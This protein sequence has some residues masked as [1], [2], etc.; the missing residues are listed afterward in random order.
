MI[1]ILLLAVGLVLLFSACGRSGRGARGKQIVVLGI[2]GM[3]PKFLEAH[4]SALP[5]LRKLSEEGEFKRLGTTVPPQSPVAWSTFITGLDPGGHGVYG[6]LHRDPATALPFS[7]LAEVSAPSR[8]IGIG[9]YELPIVAG[10]I[11]NIRKGKP[12]WQTLAEH[13]VPV[14]I[15]RMPTNF[16]PHECE[17]DAL[18]GMG[19]PDIRGTFGTFTFFTNSASEK[20]R[21][22]PGGDIVSIRLQEGHARLRIEGPSNSLRKDHARTFA[23]IEFNVTGDAAL[24]RGAGKDFILKQGEWSDW[25]PVEFGLVPGAISAHGMIRVYAKQLSPRVEIYVSPVNIDPARPELPISYPAQFSAD[26]VKRIGPFYTAGMPED[27]AAYRQGI[28]TKEEYI[29]QSRIVSREHWRLFDVTLDEFREGLLF[30]HFFGVDQDSHMLWGKDDSALLETYRSVDEAVGRVRARHANAHLIVMSD[31]G[32]NRFDR[33]VHLNSWLR[34]EGYLTLNEG[35]Q[36]GDTELFANVDWSRTRAYA[37]DLN[38][39]Y[40]NLE[41]REEKGTVAPIE[42]ASL[43]AE[44]TT[45]LLALRDHDT[46][47]QVVET[48]YDARKTYHGAEAGGGPD[49]LI[50]YSLG[51]R[52]SWQTVLG[53]VPEKLV[54]PNRD[55][56]A[57]D[58][59][60]AAHLVPGV[61][62]STKKSKRADPQLADLTVTLL[63]EFGARPERGMV[64]NSIY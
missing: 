11:K 19:T 13:D 53:A 46:G 38:S 52:A 58:H 16:P 39:L 30:F 62:L 41:G 18:S 9:P 12:F 44:I 63:S 59:C 57:G 26:L 42:S 1:R 7:S 50:G 55:A 10:K 29:A 2:D 5:N 28:F 54:E 35:S 15:M 36:P 25:R 34:K 3:D 17:G 31:H 23:E 27:T 45:R 51:Y 33:A 24:F 60:I 8:T 37:L 56:W 22:V 48:V 40:L 61:L 21:S 49:L 32:F 64:G 6:F 43:L 20:T 47:A 14:A 4:W